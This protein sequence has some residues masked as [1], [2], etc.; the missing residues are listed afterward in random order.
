[1]SGRGCPLSRLMQKNTFICTG[2]SLPGPERLNIKFNGMVHVSFSPGNTSRPRVAELLNLYKK[3][4]LE[5]K[6]ALSNSDHSIYSSWTLGNS[7]IEHVCMW[8]TLPHP[9]TLPSP[10]S[11]P[12]ILPLL[13]SLLPPPLPFQSPPFLPP[14]HP[15][16]VPRPSPLPHHT[17]SPPP[18]SLNTHTLGETI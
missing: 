13:P 18:L 14:F 17:P 6:F 9:L 4:N 11:L 7:L 12:F 16:T 3:N 8:P 15:S 10:L 1:M 2:H 5:N